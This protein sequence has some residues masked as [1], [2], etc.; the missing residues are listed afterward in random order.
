LVQLLHACDAA[1]H[2]PQDI[3]VV[4]LSAY[5]VTEMHFPA[6]VD[7]AAKA[8][9]MKGNPIVLTPEELTEILRASV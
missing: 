6:I 9:S 1:L 2:P 7:K 5:G 3:G 4:G 8:S